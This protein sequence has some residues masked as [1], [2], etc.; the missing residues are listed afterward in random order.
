MMMTYVRMRP[1]LSN[2]MKFVIVQ[3]SR[4]YRLLVLRGNY[5]FELHQCLHQPCDHNSVRGCS[6]V[7]LVLPSV[8][9]CLFVCK[10]RNAEHHFS[11][12]CYITTLGGRHCIVGFEWI[13]HW[14]LLGTHHATRSCWQG[15][16]LFSRSSITMICLMLISSIIFTFGFIWRLWLTYA[17]CQM[18][19]IWQESGVEELHFDCHYKCT[20]WILNQVKVSRC[21]AYY[22]YFI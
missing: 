15:H 8:S 9:Y 19:S 16:D 14:W 20:M 3:V 13:E 21:W 4:S 5:L 11:L 6:R 17:S 1:W 22:R 12:C 10:R 2:R 18:M 7:R